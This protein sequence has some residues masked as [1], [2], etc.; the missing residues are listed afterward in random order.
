MVFEICLGVRR[1]GLHLV[2]DIYLA[3]YHGGDEGLAVLFEEFDGLFFVGAEFVDLFGFV[4]EE[5]CDL[6]LFLI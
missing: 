5:V 3:R 1:H 4:I 6:G 2:T